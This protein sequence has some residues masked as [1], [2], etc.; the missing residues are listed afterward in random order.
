MSLLHGKDTET[1]TLLHV[2]QAAE[3]S[4]S[5]HFDLIR[6]DLDSGRELI[7]V[8]VLADDLDATGRILE[9]L[10]DLQEVH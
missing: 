9:G 3:A 6:L 4:Q 8:A 2:I 10:Q 7:L 5:N 1:T